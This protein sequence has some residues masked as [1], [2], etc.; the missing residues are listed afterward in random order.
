MTAVWT[1]L[2]TQATISRHASQFCLACCVCRGHDDSFVTTRETEGGQ[3]WTTWKLIGKLQ[4]SSPLS[5]RRQSTRSEGEY[6]PALRCSASRSPRL[7][8]VAKKPSVVGP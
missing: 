7:S 1:H 6:E 2:L 3:K 8:V 4:R 5:S